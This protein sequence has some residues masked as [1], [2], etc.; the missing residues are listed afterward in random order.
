MLDCTRIF[1]DNLQKEFNEFMR[2]EVNSAFALPKLRNNLDYERLLAAILSVLAADLEKQAD[3]D[4]ALLATD[5]SAAEKAFALLK[6]AISYSLFAGGKQIRPLCFLL[7]SRL[8]LN[9]QALSLLA[10]E[11]TAAKLTQKFANL[12]IKWQIALHLAT[13]LEMIHNY[14]LIHD[15]LPA[16]DNADYRRERL[17]NH[18]QYN[19]AIAILAGDSLLTLAAKTMHKTYALATGIVPLEA[20]F[21]KL[22]AEALN[23]L[24]DLAGTGGM[25]SGQI[26]DLEVEAAEQTVADYLLCI[27]AKTAALLQVTFTVPA[28]LFSKQV[29]HTKALAQLGNLLGFLFQIQDDRLDAAQAATENN[30]LHFMDLADLEQLETTCLQQLQQQ[31]AALF[32]E[33]NTEAVTSAADLNADAEFPAEQVELFSA[34]TCDFQDKISLQKQIAAEYKQTQSAIATLLTLLERRNK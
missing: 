17:S 5:A 24:T 30:I 33:L 27:Q 20:D 2:Q 32:A 28:L 14:S 15:D 29:Q 19:E 12:K 13:A 1:L 26:F 25:I 31:I 6:E 18:K 16:M 3:C 10:S 23:Y 7:W 9:L 4:K 34:E 8:W 21:L 11:L 22:L